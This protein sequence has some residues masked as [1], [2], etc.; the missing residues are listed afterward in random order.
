MGVAAG[1]WHM[2]RSLYFKRE[3]ESVTVDRGHAPFSDCRHPGKKPLDNN[4]MSIKFIVTHWTRPI[5]EVYRRN[6]GKYLQ[7]IEC[8]RISAKLSCKIDVDAC[9]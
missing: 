6:R 5:N 3:A 4:D 8:L 2:P 1:K 7:Y 9:A